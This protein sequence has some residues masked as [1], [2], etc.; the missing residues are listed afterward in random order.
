[1]CYYENS[2]HYFSSTY[3]QEYYD[4][5]L[6]ECCEK[7]QLNELCLSWSLYPTNLPR[8]SFNCRLYD[9]F[10]QNPQATFG[11]HSGF[12]MKST[13]FGFYS[14]NDR[15]QLKF[16]DLSGNYTFLNYRH[17][18]DTDEQEALVNIIQSIETNVIFFNLFF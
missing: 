12:N 14:V 3:L 16:F 7:C 9:T 2:T 5:N 17:V 11:F 8:N 18:Y 6:R 13:G 1:M 15:F 10:R 4:S